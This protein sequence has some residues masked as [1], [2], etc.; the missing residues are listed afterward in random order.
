MP[1]IVKKNYMAGPQTSVY[2]I[3]REWEHDTIDRP[4]DNRWLLLQRHTSQ[5]NSDELDSD[6]DKE[7]D[8]NKF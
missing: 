1:K 6:S 5:Y 4:N 7:N 2:R 3:P 8:G